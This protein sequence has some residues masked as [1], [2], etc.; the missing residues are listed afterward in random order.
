MK[1]YE[2]PT[3]VVYKGE[4]TCPFPIEGTEDDFFS[5]RQWYFEKH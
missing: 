3:E 1:Q 2:A 5:R 4:K